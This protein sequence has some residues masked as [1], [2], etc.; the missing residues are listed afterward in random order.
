[1]LRIDLT[2]FLPVV[3]HSMTITVSMV[4]PQMERHLIRITQMSLVEL[5]VTVEQLLLVSLLRQTSL[6]SKQTARQI[7]PIGRKRH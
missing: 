2:T 1:M 4:L 6:R 3:L 7:Q 5:T